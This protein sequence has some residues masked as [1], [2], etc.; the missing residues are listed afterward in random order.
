MQ[1]HLRTTI[2]L[3]LW[4]VTGIISIAQTTA[5]KTIAV[6]PK[7]NTV[8]ETTSQP[9][10]PVVNTVA[11][12]EPKAISGDP[13]KDNVAIYPFTSAAGY[14]Y[15]Y[16][17]SIGN[18]VESGFVKSNRF[19]VVERNRFGQIRQEERFKE[20]NTENIVKLAAKF[21]AKYIIS[22]H[23]TGAN[24]SM[25]YNTDHSFSGY[26]TSINLTFKII[27]VETGLIKATE[28]FSPIGSGGSAPVSKGSA[29]GIIQDF[30]RKLIALNFP[31]RFKF[32][33]VASTDTKK[34]QQILKT[35]KLWAGSD[36][37][38]QLNDLLAIY[39]VTYVTNP[40]TGKKVEEKTNIGWATLIAINSGSSSTWEIYRYSKYGAEIMEAVTK[41]PDGLLFE[42]SGAVKPK[43]LFGL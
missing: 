34:N 4:L 32:M 5:K 28:T 11:K 1:Q 16:A 31:Q 14:D 25:V 35:V 30:T 38:I 37:G 8:A 3:L 40:N 6:V 39:T 2:C 7:K 41:N 27:E 13:G 26:Q 15:D 10:A 29:Y 12:E 23:V 19:N 22:G 9:V 33:A 21:G 20:A 43:G 18:A 17:E 24:T 42:Y 36:D